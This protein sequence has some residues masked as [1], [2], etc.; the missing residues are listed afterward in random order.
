MALAAV[1]LDLLATL[2]R[3]IQP[4]SV[5]TQVP[6]EWSRLFAPPVVALLYGARL[7]VGPLTILPTWLWW[8]AFLLGAWL[9][10]LHGMA[11]GMSFAV[12][13]AVSTLGVGMWV[14]ERAA[15][16][17]G[18]LRAWEHRTAY[19]LLLLAAAGALSAT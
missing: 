4:P 12:A 11:V 6:V 9:G 18:R 14:R 13:R 2:P 1:V 19:A 15:E 17:M 10:P 3:G 8:G 7:G 16:R 5:R